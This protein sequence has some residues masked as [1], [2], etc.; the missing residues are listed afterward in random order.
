MRYVG[1]ARAS[2][3]WEERGHGAAAQDVASNGDARLFES[4]SIGLMANRYRV[5]RTNCRNVFVERTTI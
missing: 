3:E 5:S 1:H 4:T 2:R